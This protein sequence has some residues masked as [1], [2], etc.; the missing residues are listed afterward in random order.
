MCDTGWKR[1]PGGLFLTQEERGGTLC[2][3]FKEECLLSL[4][5]CLG[6]AGVRSPISVLVVW[7]PHVDRGVVSCSIINMVLGP[8]S[9]QIQTW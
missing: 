5:V 1:V 7:G 2:V 3:V 9:F 4:K 8:H 6:L